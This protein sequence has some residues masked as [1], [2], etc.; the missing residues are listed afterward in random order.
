MRFTNCWIVAMWI[1]AISLCKDYAFI[2]R[3]H[4]FMGVLPHF[5][6]AATIRWK[7]LKVIEYVPKARSAPFRGDNWVVLFAGHYRVWHLRVMGVK[8]YK[9]LK[10]ALDAE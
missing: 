8:R 5:G 9:T 2:R 1:W 3:S 7:T 4:S 10:E 6:T